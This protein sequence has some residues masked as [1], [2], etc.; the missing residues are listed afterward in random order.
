MQ[1]RERAG[2]G[3][4]ALESSGVQRTAG[5]KSQGRREPWKLVKKRV[6]GFKRQLWKG[7]E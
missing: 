3:S 7:E 5:E 6:S 1:G 2:Q 4:G